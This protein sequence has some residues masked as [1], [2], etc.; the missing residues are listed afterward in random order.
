MGTENISWL[1]HST[2]QYFSLKLFHKPHM[3]RKDYTE[4]KT[5]QNKII[6]QQIII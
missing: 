2:L 3:Y 6:L 1:H 4:E 5:E